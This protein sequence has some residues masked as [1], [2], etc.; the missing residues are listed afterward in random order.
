M[1]ENCDVF[2]LGGGPAGSTAAALLAE[3]GWK[4][5]IV[6]KERHP[7]FHIGESMLPMST[8]LFERL[9]VRE[10]VEKIGMVKHGAE[11]VSP[12]AKQAVTFDFSEAW[13]AVPVLL[14]MI[15]T[16]SLPVISP[17]TVVPVSVVTR[18]SV[19]SSASE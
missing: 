4:V 1:Q 18:G 7:R 16:G 13:N 12:Q 9:G 8:P 11:F 6:D 5:V 10:E 14:L 3:R 17:P 15:E 2:I 19:R